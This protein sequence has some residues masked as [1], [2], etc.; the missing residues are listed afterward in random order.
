MAFIR[1]ENEKG[2]KSSFYRSCFCCLR[3]DY[4]GV[5]EA[6]NN[7]CLKNEN[8]REMA[9]NLKLKGNF[10]LVLLAMYNYLNL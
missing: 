1:S 6:S 10:V 4:T 5:F 3:I 2:E 9:N 8:V 7:F